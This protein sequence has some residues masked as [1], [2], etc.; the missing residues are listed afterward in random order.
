MLNKDNAQLTTDLETSDKAKKRSLALIKIISLSIGVIGIVGDLASALLSGNITTSIPNLVAGSVIAIAGFSNYAIAQKGKLE[1]ATTLLV[2][3]VFIGAI[4]F[5]L[6]NVHTDSLAGAFIL[7]PILAGILGLSSR[8][9]SIM[10]VLAGL[11][12]IITSVVRSFINPTDNSNSFEM[13]NWLLIYI[14]CAIGITVFTRRL[15]SAARLAESQNVKLNGL[16][17]S[18]RDVTEASATISQELALVTQKLK[19]SSEKQKASAEEQAAAI[20]Q[21]TSIMEELNTNA[22]IIASNTEIVTRLAEETVNVANMVKEAS[23]QA[24]AAALTGNKSVEEAVSSVQKMR[25]H[26]EVMTVSLQNLA[27]QAQNVGKVIDVIAEIASETHLLALNASIEAQGGT[28]AN[29][30]IDNVQGMRF[31]IIAQEIKNL[32]DR[33]RNST[34]NMKLN[35]EQMQESVDGAGQIAGIGRNE[36]FSAVERSQIA[37]AVIGR[38]TQMVEISYD[39]ANQILEANSNVKSLCDEINLAT[40]QQR[41][42]YQQTFGSIRE[43]NHAM[44]DGANVAIQLAELA[45]RVRKQVGTLNKQL[46]AGLNDN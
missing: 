45:D 42:A 7:V 10:S 15:G 34:K 40:R 20:T 14:L 16:V 3:V 25:E 12:L 17:T 26:I 5:Q 29:N 39:Q 2:I 31:E 37:G 18:L 28:Y 4:V 44:Q 22:D 46:E 36:A 38:L 1:I 6:I 21:T 32:S 41:S 11:G 43:L 30:G 27:T 35:I 19:E 24:K 23:K 13:V 9:T 8:Q 33:S